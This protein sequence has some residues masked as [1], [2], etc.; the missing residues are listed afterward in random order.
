VVRVGALLAATGLA[1]GV[2]ADSVPAAL[3]GWAVF[4]LGLSGTVPSLITAA[5]SHGP[6]A[7]A[8][9]SVTGYLGLLA[10]PGLIGALA[11]ITTLPTA[12]LRRHPRL[13]RRHRT[14]AHPRPL[15]S[16]GPHRLLA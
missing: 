14:A 4:G 3:A 10:G 16:T 1:T 9:V 7:V 5:G 13:Q 15:A 6:R 2:L 8:T 12:L 11:S